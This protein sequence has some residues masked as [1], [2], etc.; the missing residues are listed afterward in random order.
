MSPDILAY[1]TSFLE[2][3][4][5]GEP[6]HTFQT[7]HDR[8]KDQP[9]PVVTGTLAQHA[10]YLER[11]QAAGHGVFWTVNRTDGHGRE[12]HNVTGIRAVWLDIDEA[13]R[14]ITPIIQA[15]RPHAVVE[16]SPGKH[17]IYWR[18][19]DCSLAQ[20]QP[21][22]RAL[23]ERWGGDPGATG[24]NRVLRLPGFW[25]LK[26][27]PALTRI[28]QWEPELPPYQVAHIE[29]YLLGGQVSAAASTPVD[30]S[31]HNGAVEDWR[32]PISEVELH[33]R[34]NGQHRGAPSVG[35]AFGGGWSLHE[36]WAPDLH[37][38]EAS[39]QRSEARM[40]LLTRLMYLTGG[41]SARVHTL[42]KDHPLAVK[43]GRED[44]LLTELGKARATFMA[45]WE[46]E[47]AKRL[48]QR[49]ETVQ[50]AADLPTGQS[51]APQVLTLDEMLGEL[52]YVARGRGVVLRKSKVSLKFEDAAGLFAA[53][54]TEVTSDDGQVK[55]VSNLAS[56]LAH[57]ERRLTVGLMTWRPGQGEF[58]EPL[59]MIDGHE[60]AYNMWRGLRRNHPPENWR[61]WAAW[62]EHHVA[63]LVPIE[64]ERRRFLQWLGHI[65]QRPGELPHTAYLMV[66]ETT[67]TGRNWL[68]SCLARCLAGYC[69]LGVSL[70]PILDGKFNG[71][72]SQKLLATVDEVREGMEGDR[73]GRGEALKK[74][75]TEERRQ[76]DHKYGMQ[77]VEQ[78]CC[79]WLIFSNHR[80]DA[81]PFDQTDRRLCVIDNPTHRQSPD[82]YAQLYGLLDRPQFV[83]SVR[84]YLEQVSLEGFNAGEPAPFNDAKQRMLDGMTGPL[85]KAVASFRASWK[86]P[87]CGLSDI[88]GYVQALTG[89]KPRGPALRHVLRR[90]RIEE[91]AAVEVDGRPEVALFLGGAPVENVAQSIKQ[92]RASKAFTA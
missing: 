6:Q 13:G 84:H 75:I 46:P 71:I 19:S 47:R 34:L 26:G 32:N 42:V 49:A 55:K 45:W 73:Y 64:I 18:V 66:T 5:P 76:I 11:M 69:A 28:A 59:E 85:D 54:K 43:D 17:H 29:H 24:I 50:L 79:R 27:E 20:A 68:S 1:A 33:A 80:S 52:V 40:A 92:A 77:V 36:L 30:T 37:Q 12:L 58:C 53:S 51:L 48:A 7:F 88:V 86:F 61:E 65:F 72:L 78:N 62:F 57:P 39:K 23:R 4:A 41:D 8:A 10:E 38:L 81:L 3:L 25:H 83:A 89:E 70:G 87:V 16:S 63:Y 22:L 91:L 9:G 44:L 15:L 74:T 82:Y 14:D 90:H 21:L 60:S 31:L 35:E 2:C 67:G 56:W